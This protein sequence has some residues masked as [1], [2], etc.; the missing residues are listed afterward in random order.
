MEIRG[1]MQAALR[2]RLVDHLPAA[3]ETVWDAQSVVVAIEKMNVTPASGH[4]APEW[5]LR[6]KM[7]GQ[8]V[9]E[10]RADQIDQMALEPL[11]VSLMGDPLWMSLPDPADM[12]MGGVTVCG[13][14]V[15]LS[16]RDV[17]RDG[18]VVT[19]LRFTVDGWIVQHVAPGAAPDQVMV[20]QAPR[21]GPDHTGDYEAAP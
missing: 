17:L 11:L 4:H 8:V 2:A 6:G 16:L 19:A 5:A 13:R 21:I 1:K 12:P 20:G 7:T 10:I 9:A 14:A 15:L 18:G 3:L